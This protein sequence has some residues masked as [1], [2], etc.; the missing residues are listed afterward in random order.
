MV[1]VG[2]V[3]R[4]TAKPGLGAQVADF[5]KSATP[6]AEAEEFTPAWFAYQADEHTFYITDVFESEADRNKHVE[7]PIAQALFAKA[8]ELLACAPEIVPVNVLGAKL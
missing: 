3:V 8:P 5:L 6:L 4:L 7:G 2:L 1:K